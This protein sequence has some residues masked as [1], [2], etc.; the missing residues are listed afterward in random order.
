[1]GV[2]ESLNMPSRVMSLRFPS[3]FLIFSVVLSVS[4]TN[5]IVYY[6]CSK[7]CFDSV[8]PY[9]SNLNSLFTS[10]IDS[11]CVSGFNRIEISQNDVVVYGLFQCQGD[12][13]SAKCKDCVTNS[14]NQLKATCPMSISGTIQLEEGCFVKY[15]NISFF[16]TQNKMEVLKTCGTSIGYNSD[17][18]NRIDEAL[19]YLTV[20]NEQYFRSEESGSFQGVAQCVQDL[21]VS[22]CQDCLSEAC[23]RLRT[24]C[25]TSIWADMFLG[26]CYLRYADQGNLSN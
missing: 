9:E 7:F 25:V 13:N 24:E 6:D 17:V 16:G 14:I 4:A 8:T 22:D 18:L 19:T 26:K 3:L 2:I 10:L 15:D 12:V 21:S 1:M 5:S 23:G 11:S 20:G